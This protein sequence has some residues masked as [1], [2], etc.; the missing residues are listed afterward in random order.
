MNL[1]HINCPILFL[2]PSNDFHGR[3]NH[4]PAAVREIQSAVWRVTCSPHHN[5]QDTPKYEVAIQ[6]WFD[7][8]MKGTFTCP[9][10][11]KTSLDL[12]SVDG[13]PSFTVGPDASQPIL[14]LDIYYTQKGQEK[15]EITNRENRMARRKA[16]IPQ[17]ALDTGRDKAFPLIQLGNPLEDS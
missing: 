4:L 9:E 5:H 10:I 17:P 7:R 16:G 12:N 13:I 8:H 1:K 14:Y 6:L 11:S 15:G 3:I 2:S